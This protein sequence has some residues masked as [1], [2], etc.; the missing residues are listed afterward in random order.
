MGYSDVVVRVSIDVLGPLYILL[1]P[2]VDSIHFYQVRDVQAEGMPWQLAR[3][4]IS[5]IC[6]SLG[7]PW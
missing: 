7:M 4:P 1:E 2:V 5:P 3:P 6:Y